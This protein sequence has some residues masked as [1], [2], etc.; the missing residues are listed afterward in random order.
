MKNPFVVGVLAVLI[1][2][3][4]GSALAYRFG[5]FSLSATSPKP[6]PA[7]SGKVMS[8]ES[9]V[10]QNIS[11]L[12]PEKEVLGGTFY[13]TDIQAVDGKGVVSYEDGHIALIADFA[14]TADDRTGIQIT[15]FVIR[16]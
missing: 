7:P 5:L 2:A 9:Y 13:V 15:S 14:Y 16:K 11:A 12:S 3:L 8:I 6:A 4:V 1:L 10:R